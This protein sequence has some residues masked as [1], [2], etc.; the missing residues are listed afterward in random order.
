MVNRRTALKLGATG[1]LGSLSNLSSTALASDLKDQQTKH[2]LGIFDS[3]YKESKTFSETLV[4]NGIASLDI[5]KSLSDL[6]Y[7]ELRNSLRDNPKTLFGLT[8]RASLFCIEELARDLNMK[9]HTRIDHL[10]DQHGNIEHASASDN[11]N[12]ATKLLSNNFGRQIAEATE[13]TEKPS[14]GQSTVSTQKLTGPSAPANTIALVS[15]VIS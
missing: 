8:D 5:Q 6:W 7:N 4:N 14:N 11:L 10:I 12:E 1:F 13:L 3:N 15:W 2:L 9:V